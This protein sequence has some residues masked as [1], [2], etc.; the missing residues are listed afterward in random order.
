MLHLHL[1]C[2][3]FRRIV[4]KCIIMNMKRGSLAFALLLL[5]GFAALLTIN[6]NTVNNALSTI[7]GGLKRRH[8]ASMSLCWGGELAFN[9]FNI[10]AHA[11][12]IYY[13][14]SEN[15]KVFGKANF[16]YFEAAYYSSM[17]WHTQAKGKVVHGTL[18]QKPPN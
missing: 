12:C 9:R 18:L 16:P 17:L 5:L 1:G 4:G 7:S 13:N 10:G 15:A 6:V 11:H 14:F 3:Y 2:Y 8:W